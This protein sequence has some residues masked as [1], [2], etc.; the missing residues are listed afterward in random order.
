MS[1][2]VTKVIIRDSNGQVQ[3]TKFHSYKKQKL[4]KESANKIKLLERQLDK[5]KDNLRNLTKPR[6][7][8]FQIGRLA[9]HVATTVE[10]YPDDT[11]DKW[12]QHLKDLIN[13]DRNLPN[14]FQ[15]EIASKYNG[16]VGPTD[17]IQ[18]FFEYF[19]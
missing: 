3:T 18:E 19:G 2:K 6:L 13:E 7:T 5:E 14:Y 4:A 16:I 10:L 11:T 9:A 17:L 8:P 12:G 1:K 15:T